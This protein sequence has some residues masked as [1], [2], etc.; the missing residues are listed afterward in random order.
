MTEAK[1]TTPKKKAPPNPNRVAVLETHV[2][3]RLIIRA[4]PALKDVKS[5]VAEQNRRYEAGE[6]GGPSGIPPYQIHEAAYFP[7]ELDIDD[8]KKGTKIKL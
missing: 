7:S 4:N 3:E 1:K 6:P 5:F 8:P 2:G